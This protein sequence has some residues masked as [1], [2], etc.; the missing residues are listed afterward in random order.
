MNSASARL[1]YLLWI[2]KRP[3]AR[4]FPRSCRDRLKSQDP[5]AFLSHEHVSTLPPRGCKMLWQGKQQAPQL[6]LAARWLRARFGRGCRA[7]LSRP[8]QQQKER[9]WRNRA[10]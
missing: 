8:Q 1:F 3:R 6:L 4:L 10:T 5:E 7:A 9:K 2:P